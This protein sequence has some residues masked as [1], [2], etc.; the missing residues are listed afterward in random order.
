VR[1]FLVL[2][3]IPMV[4]NA[5]P[6][7]ATRYLAG[8]PASLFDIGMLRLDRLASEFRNRVGLHWTDD[9]EYHWFRAEINASYVPEDDKIYIGFSIMDSEPT[10]QQMEEGCRNAMLQMNI[11]VQ[12]SLPGLFL[13]TGY[14]HGD[15][16]VPPDLDKN[17]RN[18][19]EI[20]CY[21]SSSRDT[22]EGRFWASRTLGPLGDDQMK[23]GKWKMRN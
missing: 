7:P 10:Q 6:G 8:E 22:S 11:W 4:A 13:H 1:K 16:S 14:E 20:R 21:F 19:F 3:L 5:E 9:G 23:I 17:L 18:M 15:S 12:K 2:L